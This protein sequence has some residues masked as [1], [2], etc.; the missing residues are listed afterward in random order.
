MSNAKVGL[1]TVVNLTTPEALESLCKE[2]MKMLNP[3]L[4][5]IAA[6]NSAIQFVISGEEGEIIKGEKFLSSQKSIRSI[7]R[8]KGVSC[9]FHSP[10]MAKAAAQFELEA[11]LLL[12]DVSITAIPVLSNVTAQPV[13]S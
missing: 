13:D 11:K 6:I 8:L 12:K 1:M 10:L 7:K 9:A 4:V 2:T 5:G 3:E